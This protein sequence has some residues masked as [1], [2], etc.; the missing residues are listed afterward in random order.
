M[1]TRSRRSLHYPYPPPVQLSRDQS[2]KKT[3]DVGSKRLHHLK[4]ME[5]ETM[6]LLQ[7][8]FS[9]LKERVW[10]RILP[11][12]EDYDD[13]A[14][15]MGLQWEDFL[16]LLLHGG[17]LYTEKRSTVNSYLLNHFSW[18]TFCFS[19][20]PSTRSTRRQDDSL[21]RLNLGYFVN[22]K[23]TR[24]HF[25][26]RGRPT[27]PSP[28]KQLQAVAD[29]SFVFLD[30]RSGGNLK[31]RVATHARLLLSTYLMHR[32][33]AGTNSIV[34]QPRKESNNVD[35]DNADTLYS[36]TENAISFA[37]ALDLDRRPRM[38]REGT[39]EVAVHNRKQAL[40]TEKMMC[41]F[42]AKRWG[43]KDPAI[44][45]KKRKRI[46]R[47]A[48]RQVA[49]DYGYATELSSSMLPQWEGRLHSAIDT[50]AVDSSSSHPN[51]LSPRH[52]GKQSYCDMIEAE[53]PGYLRELFRYAQR[54]NGAKAT[55]KELADTMN[56]KSEIEGE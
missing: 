5:E 49:Y 18:Q 41:L 22:K 7:D 13:V 1:Q 45:C 4:E 53:H 24:T 26:C 25:I 50:G 40:E 44:H 34:L 35:V 10:W 20:V 29:G 8:G 47:A 37:L 17:F 3:Q 27:F 39:S 56:L 33:N 46:A 14:F 43:W 51:P 21:A 36:D 31:R 42:T 54:T 19:F 9:A 55:F 28:G 6:R 11:I 16:P 23:G 52:C 38:N 15:G 48:C 2:D 32:Y 30:I 12:E